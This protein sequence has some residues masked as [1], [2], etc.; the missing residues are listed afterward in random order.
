MNKISKKIEATIKAE[1]KKKEQLITILK[2]DQD[3]YKCDN[4]KKIAELEAVINYYQGI[5]DNS[6]GA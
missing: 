6:K 4:S 3:D 2:H 1:I 5:I